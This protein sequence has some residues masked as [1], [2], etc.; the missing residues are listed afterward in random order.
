MRKIKV[1]VVDDSIFFL[2]YIMSG[3]SAFEDIEIA[4]CAVNAVDAEHKI[5]LLR[6]D[7]VT[8]DIEMPGMSGLDF[9][10]K[11][12]PADPIPVILVSAL[13]LK[14]FD[15][16]AAGAVDFV[17]KPDTAASGGA[18]LFLSSLHSKLLNAAQARVR[19]PQVPLMAS[20]SLSSSMA[21]SHFSKV[22]MMADPQAVIAIG[23]STGGTEA[24]LE[25][26]RQLPA[27]LPPVVITQHMPP[28]FTDMYAKRLD[29][30][31][32]L[33]VR[34]AKNG[35]A[36]RRGLALIAPGGMQ[37]KLLK[38]SLGYSVSCY[39]GDRVNGLAPSVDVLFHSAAECAGSH[40][41]GVILT[42]MGR[43]GAEGLLHMRQEGAYT[44]GQDRESCVV[45]GMP[46]E[47]SELGAVCRQVTLSG[48]SSAL[49]NYLAKQP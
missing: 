21:P 16:L 8:L 38:S 25:V 41:V 24:I 26:L 40:G 27:D 4:G 35:D 49:L 46:M 42:G 48:I 17:K 11:L 36:L 15:A 10:K 9:L 32:N 34:E 22:S 2:K 3:L 39:S 12:L 18:D 5:K 30:L 13:N 20:V 23:A 6:P 19:V 29:R 33:E 7:V 31:T 28:G 14:L 1:L 37:M 44:L 45:Y 47:A 43:D